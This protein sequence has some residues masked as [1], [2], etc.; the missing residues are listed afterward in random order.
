MNALVDAA[1][2]HPLGLE[3]SAGGGPAHRSLFASLSREMC[4]PLIS[5]RAGFDLLLAGCE[6]PISDAQRDQVQTLRAQC[7]SL[8]ALTRS[9]LDY[10]GPARAPRPTDLAPYRLGALLAEADRQFAGAARARGIDWACR[11]AGEDGPVVTDLACFQRVVGQLVANALDH[12]SDGGRIVVIGRT[13][14][15]CWWVEVA[16]D[17]RGIPSEALGHVFEPLVRLGS[18][19]GA[20]HGMGLPVCRELVARL[21]GEIVLRSEP[22]TG[23][24][25]RVV[26][27]TE[28][29]QGP[30]ATG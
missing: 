21:G 4:G 19:S 26:F 16:D 12:T 22:G 17:G 29:A 20:G 27:A 10:A 18:G 28:T 5:L 23:T 2:Q 7:D 1:H 11:V 25:V 15:D 13:G 3:G 24:V 14:P 30:D 9:F 6:G 8:I